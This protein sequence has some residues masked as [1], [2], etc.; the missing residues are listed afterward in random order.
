[1]T[2]DEVRF[3][4]IIRVVFHENEYWEAN[5]MTRP[6]TTTGDTVG[7]FEEENRKDR[8]KTAIVDGFSPLY[9][10]WDTYPDHIQHTT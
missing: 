8:M 6:H 1:M 9:F 5:L 4:T 3:M 10:I 2:G 7:G